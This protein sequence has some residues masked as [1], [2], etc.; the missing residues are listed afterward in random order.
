MTN[1]FSR[2]FAVDTEPTEFDFETKEELLNHPKVIEYL[3][4]PTFS[5]YGK[6]D[7]M[8]FAVTSNRMLWIVGYIT[9]PDDLDLPVV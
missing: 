8:L 3:A 1:H 9:N 5:N 2:N 4:I 7:N 6:R